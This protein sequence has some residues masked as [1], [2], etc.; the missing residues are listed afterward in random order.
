MTNDMH[1]IDCPTA[2]VAGSGIRASA[3]AAFMIPLLTIGLQPL[4]AQQV[5]VCNGTI[6]AS[7]LRPVA[8]PLVVELEHPIDSVANPGLA[9]AFL[10]GLQKAGATVVSKGR[11][12]TKLDLSFLMRSTRGKTGTY[13]NLNWMR[14]QPAPGHIQ[15]VLRGS[16]VEVTIYAHGASSR[17]LIWTG[18]ISCTIQTDDVTTLAEGL[19]KIV[20]RSLGET[21]SKSTL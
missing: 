10:D 14:S 15:S 5:K 8:K 3:L 11:G 20:G 7:P 12:T 9:K 4:A 1:G 2:R 16:H 13:R 6:S 19:G 18:T 17:A 21:V